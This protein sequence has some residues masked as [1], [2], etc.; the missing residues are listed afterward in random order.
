M[1]SGYSAPLSL[2]SL[3]DL[4]MCALNSQYVLLR[5]RSRSRSIS[6]ASRTAILLYDLGRSAYRRSDT[7]PSIYYS[8][9]FYLIGGAETYTVSPSYWLNFPLSLQLFCSIGFL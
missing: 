1:G 2:L 9:G 6:S 5:N 8:R 7:C 3:F 4:S